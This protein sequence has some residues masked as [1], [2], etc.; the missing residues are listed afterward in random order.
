MRK[1]FVSTLLFLLVFALVF[2]ALNWIFLPK[3]NSKAAGFSQETSVGF[4]A[5]PENTL[6]VLILGDS[7]VYSGFIPLQIWQ[8]QG[9]TA[10]CVSTPAQKLYDTYDLL[11]QALKNQSP[12][13]VLLET[14]AI[15][16]D[17]SVVDVLEA[18]LQNKLPYIKYHD[19][20]KDLT[21]R[22]LTGPLAYTTRQRDKG[23]IYMTD[24]A[25]ALP[26]DDTPDDGSARALS[27]MNGVYMEKIAQLCGSRGIR[28]IL[29]TAPSPS[30]W[31][32]YYHNGWQQLAGELG[33]THLDMNLLR[34]EIPI[35][36]QTECYDEG[37]HLNYFGARKTTAYLGRYL[38]DTGLFTDKRENPEYADWNRCLADFQ[39]EIQ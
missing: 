15:F 26:Y 2:G 10:Y 11:R 1:H 16:Q 39:R 31:S 20:W 14:D 8:E 6:D 21:L 30:G 22:D 24:A 13:V 23:Y 29:V 38:W 25:P 5:E 32:W 18:E 28:L 34:Q 19:R 35:D 27:A 37:E 33:I 4:L 17:I 9:I 3:D 7:R 12:K 36:W